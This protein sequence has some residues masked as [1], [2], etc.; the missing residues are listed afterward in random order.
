MLETGKGLQHEMV[1]LITQPTCAAGRML[2]E[3]TRRSRP[4]GWRRSRTSRMPHSHAHSGRDATVRRCLGLLGVS[5]L[6]FSCSATAN[7]TETPD[8]GDTVLSASPAVPGQ[9]YTGELSVPE[10]AD[11]YQVDVKRPLTAIQV[12][13][14]QL[15]DVCEAW[16]RLVSLDGLVLDQVIAS[17]HEVRSLNVVTAS[18]GPY[19]VA[20]D[21]GSAAT[22]GGATYSV[23]ITLADAAPSLRAFAAP[24][25]LSRPTRPSYFPCQTWSGRANYLA[26]AIHRTERAVRRARGATK[27]RL[28][29]KLKRSRRDYRQAR[30]LQRYWC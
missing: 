25:A 9:T 8:P 17:R 18:G 1:A 6:V 12:S 15:N 16:V 14:R 20:V 23:D 4:A 3:S 10:D 26:V 28:Q 5:L 21:H 30:K 29:R 19:F 2:V 24:R 22:C 13:V 7:A 11:W 27:R